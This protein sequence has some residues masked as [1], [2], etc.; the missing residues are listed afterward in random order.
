MVVKNEEQIV[1]GV[2]LL[3]L[4]GVILICFNH[5]SITILKGT[6]FFPPLTYGD[7]AT[8]GISLIF[9]T[10]GFLNDFIRTD[11]DYNR[12][13]FII[14]NYIYLIIPAIFSLVIDY[15]IINYASLS[16]SF[17]PDRAMPFLVTLTQTWYYKVLGSTS[18]AEPM[19]GSNMNWLAS[20]IFFLVIFFAV[21]KRLFE[22]VSKN[23]NILFFLY[24]ASLVLSATQIIL[25]EKFSG[26]IGNYSVDHYGSEIAH[27]YSLIA[28]IIEYSP[29]SHIFEFCTG[30]FL[31]KIVTKSSSSRI[32]MAGLMPTLLISFSSN[33][34]I[35]YLGFCVLLI[36]I[37]F[38]MIQLLSNE[39][40]LL[41]RLKIGG[42]IN[43]IASC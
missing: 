13:N 20:N 5:F 4:F 27:A 33:V 15:F 34:A 12:F 37:S 41:S 18:L 25:I 42:V 26:D 19:G 11:I 30:I 36:L 31:S 22:T 17:D 8:L 9:I 21:T 32:V 35:K 29:Y 39:S 7:C 28:W 2:Q 23:K 38:Y 14:K 6:P 43:K 3:Q 1:T 24:T 40:R 16:I 10:S